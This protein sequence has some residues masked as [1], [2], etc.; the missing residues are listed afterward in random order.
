M[1]LQ[2][3]FQGLRESYLEGSVN[4]TSMEK[5]VLIQGLQ[6]L[7]RAVHED[8]VAIELFPESEWTCPSGLVVKDAEEEK[9]QKAT[10]DD[11]DDEVNPDEMMDVDKAVQKPVDKLLI[12]PTG[13]VVGIIKRNWRPYCGML[14]P[15][16]SGAS[17]QT[18]HRHTFIPADQRVPH[19]RLETRQASVLMGKRIIVSIDSWPHSS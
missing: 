8:I 18:T 9:V 5:F 2:G 1:Y 13:K 19:V 11:S 15:L 4:V 12:Q 6:H 7:N 16:T 17:L 3:P 10:N 14:L